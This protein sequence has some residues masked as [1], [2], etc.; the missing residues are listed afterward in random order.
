MFEGMRE[1]LEG[2]IFDEMRRRFRVST[3]GWSASEK[4]RFAQMG[5]FVLAVPGLEKWPEKE[6]QAVLDL[7]RLKGSACEADYARAFRRNRKF[8]AELRKV[9]E[10]TAEGRTQ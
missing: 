3:E 4:T 7:C 1:G 2:R 6:R 9:A 5:L 8:F 10:R